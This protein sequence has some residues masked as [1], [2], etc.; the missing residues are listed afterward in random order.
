[1]L[2]IVHIKLQLI[3]TTNGSLW[4]IQEID[5]ILH[6]LQRIGKPESCN[7]GAVSSFQG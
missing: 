6:A 4:C 7:E 2:R 5:S 3:E 1:M